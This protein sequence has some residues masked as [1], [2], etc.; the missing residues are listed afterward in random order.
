MSKIIT[1]GTHCVEEMVDLKRPQRKN[2]S[3]RSYELNSPEPVFTARY[4]GMGIVR[5]DFVPD[6]ANAVCTKHVE[7]LLQIL[8]NKTKPRKV[9]MSISTNIF[10]GLTIAEFGS[11]TEMSF[12]LHSIAFCCTDKRNPKIFSF[13]ADRDSEHQCHTF[14]CKTQEQATEICRALSNAFLSAHSEWTRRRKRQEGRKETENKISQRYRWQSE[15][16][17][18]NSKF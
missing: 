4:L 3:E 12:Q 11:K 17:E 8:E 18:A 10:R 1:F 14:L 16:N 7:Q 9:E 15:V 13:I 5:E 6:K 2:S